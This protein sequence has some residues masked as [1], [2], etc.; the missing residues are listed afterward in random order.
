M[1]AARHAPAH[2]LLF[3]SDEEEL[4]E[5]VGARLAEAHA[6]GALVVLLATAEHATGI[7]ARL[8][9]LGVEP[10]AARRDGS[11]VVFEAGEA[12][13]RLTPAGPFDVAAFRDLTDELL[14]PAVA[15]R[16]V[17]VFGEIVDLFWAD[18]RI[19][20]AI[21]LEAAWHELL[22]EL[23]ASLI[24]AYSG[25]MLEH[26]HSTDVAAVCDLHATIIAEGP[27]ERT[28]SFPAERTT[29]TAARHAATKLLLSRG[30]AARIVADAQVV[31]GE[32]VAN[33]V[34]HARTPYSVTV[35]VTDA[36][37]VVEVGDDSPTPP[38]EREASSDASSGRGLRLLSAVS[39]R[40]GVR[41]APTS[42]VVWAELAR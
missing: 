10:D 40:W 36:T 1:M 8:R 26:A 20:D 11:L 15:V 9:T 19:E 4:L 12:L 13:A 2:A 22:A 23:P 3:P 32:L 28:W 21:A 33:A 31:V 7:V 30:L 35:R 39:E 5:I 38:E 16:P 34:V 6:A 14:R 37:V 17:A 25:T 29:P 24:C 18:G 27:F 41:T 42:K